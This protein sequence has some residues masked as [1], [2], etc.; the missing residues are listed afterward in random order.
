MCIRDSSTIIK[1]IQDDVNE[2]RKRK[3]S[4]KDTG[5]CMEK[6]NNEAIENKVIGSDSEDSE[7][8]SDNHNGEMM[9]NNNKVIVDKV[10]ENENSD[11]YHSEITSNN[12]NIVENEVS[13]ND[14]LSKSRDCLLYTSRCV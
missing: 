3:E 13:K 8:I 4:K 1:Q 7:N 9:T 14:T 5:K 12:G 2:I 10:S 11:N 6:I